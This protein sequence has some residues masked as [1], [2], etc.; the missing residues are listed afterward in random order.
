MEWAGGIPKSRHSKYHEKVKKKAGKASKCEN[1][2][3]SYPNPKRYEWALRKGHSYSADPADYIQLCPSCHRKYDYTE[4]HKNKLKAAKYG[5]KHNAA[6]LKND[7][8]IEIRD[9]IKSG[10][11]LTDIAKKYNVHPTTISDIKSG[12]RWGYLTKQQ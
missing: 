3:C 7:Q 4:D 11:K 2:D 12:K 6:K 8:V 9:L 10:A 5:D 1:P